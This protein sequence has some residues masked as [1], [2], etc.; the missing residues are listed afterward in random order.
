MTIK[1]PWTREV[2]EGLNRWQ[3]SGVVHPYTCPIH[4]DIPLIAKKSGFHC[5][6]CNYTQ[7]WCHDVVADNLPLTKKKLKKMFR[8][9]RGD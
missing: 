8:K 2:V 1:T 7:D 4:S 6:K 3:C 5:V 9:D